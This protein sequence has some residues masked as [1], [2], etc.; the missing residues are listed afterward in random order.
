MVYL[1]RSFF[2]YFE[3]AKNLG[4]SDDTKQR[5]KKEDGLMTL[6]DNPCN[7]CYIGGI[8][9]FT[10]FFNFCHGQVWETLS[11]PLKRAP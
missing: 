7:I 5:K 1:R 6:E 11:T 4:W 10:L 3:N 8:D 9:L 2:F